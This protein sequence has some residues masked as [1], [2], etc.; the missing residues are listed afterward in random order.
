MHSALAAACPHAAII[1][2]PG[3]K[4]LHALGLGPRYCLEVVSP[5]GGQ[6]AA[7]AALAERGALRPSVDRVLPLERIAC[8]CAGA[9]PGAHLLA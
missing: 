7:L 8:V 5:D 4:L 6:L 1:L 2:H 9:P 3:S